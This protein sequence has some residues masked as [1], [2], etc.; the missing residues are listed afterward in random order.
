MNAPG[1]TERTVVT[2]VF[3][4][5]VWFGVGGCAATGGVRSA[6]RLDEPDRIGDPV[7]ARAIAL[8]GAGVAVLGLT[9]GIAVAVSGGGSDDDRA[10]V[11]A[12]HPAPWPP[13]GHRRR[14]RL[15]SPPPLPRRLRRH[16]RRPR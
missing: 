7:S 11:T 16:R 13:L 6:A 9:F 15:L 10:D 2:V 3:G 8:I 5:P 1:A 14:R 4:A 12:C